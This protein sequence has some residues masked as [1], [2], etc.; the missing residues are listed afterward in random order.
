MILQITCRLRFNRLFKWGNVMKVYGKVTILCIVI[1]IYSFTL[2]FSLLDVKANAHTSNQSGPFQ[3]F[4]P[5]ILWQ[6]LPGYYVSPNGSDANPGTLL[7]PWRTIG[8]AAR[9]VIP[10]D[11]VYVRAGIYNEAV[12]LDVSGTEQKP[13][14]FL[15][16]PGETP[17]V[18]GNNQ[19]PTTWTGLFHVKGDWIRISGFEV[20]NSAYVGV[21]LH[22]QHDRADHI[23]SHH[24][25]RNGIYVQGDYGTVENSNLW[26]NAMVN[27]NNKAGNGSSALT[28]ARDAK[29]GIT[30]YAVLRN[31]IV[32]E[33]WGI[34][35]DS[36]ESNGTLI[37][38]NILHDNLIGNI[39]ISDA[40]HVVCI[41]N[42]LYMTPGNITYGLSSNF[43]ILLGDEL[44]TPPSAYITIIN[45]IAY[46]NNHNLKWYSGVQGGGMN[47]VLIAN[48]T[49][50]NA[51]PNDNG[52]RN[53]DVG[54]GTHVN[55]RI[56]NNIIVQDD[57]QPIED[58]AIDPDIVI[59]H[60]LWSKP[61]RDA[62]LG[63]GDV[64]GDP[65]LARTGTPFDYHW[66]VLSNGSPAIDNAL[67][68]PE[69]INDFLNSV[70]GESPDIGALEYLYQP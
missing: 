21:Q 33:N 15:A 22:G 53:V 55:V 58:I 36:Y 35:I 39:Y 10:G 27:E 52:N 63:S 26:R 40:T 32:W 11:T 19:L 38:G 9:T 68:L 12:S 45:N 60:N 4:L 1:F 18:E 17:I 42:F 2:Q 7:R 49:F 34:G 28:T 44:Y 54:S 67:S 20:R 65:K 43:G 24:N 8:K 61:P 50:V 56:M 69:V 70:R 16:Y 31:N 13:I 41:S 30:D 51:M 14:S 47:N 64:V 23:F 29:D 6:V 5:Q 62:I 37:E 66:F 57:S 59:S 48:N 46:G 25:Q 3:I